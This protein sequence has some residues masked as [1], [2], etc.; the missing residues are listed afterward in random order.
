MGDDAKI[1]EAPASPGDGLSSLI[2]AR[3]AE[4]ERATLGPWEIHRNNPYRVVVNTGYRGVDTVA[5]CES[6]RHY[7]RGDRNRARI[8]RSANVAFIASARTGYPAALRAA[9]VLAAALE[10]MAELSVKCFKCDGTQRSL[11]G[12]TCEVCGGTGK[13]VVQRDARI[14]AALAAAAREI[15][16]EVGQ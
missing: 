3:L 1:E 5:D 11:H 2:A 9:G 4:C 12:T 8:D 15:G 7:W 14:D 13:L 16:A 10:S 6:L